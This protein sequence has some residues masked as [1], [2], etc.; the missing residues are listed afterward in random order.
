MSSFCE[1]RPLFPTVEIALESSKK[2]YNLNQLKLY[3]EFQILTFHEISHLSPTTV[4]IIR[5]KDKLTTTGRKE[6]PY[7]IRRA[8]I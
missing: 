3:A 1:L 7:L 5:E 4:T 6:K 8:T 2:F